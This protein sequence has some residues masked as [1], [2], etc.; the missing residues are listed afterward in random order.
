[1]GTMADKLR[2]IL[3][4][5]KAI[6]T[7]L[8]NKGAS[9]NDSTPFRAYARAIDNMSFADEGGGGGGSGEQEIAY[10]DFIYNME[11]EECTPNCSYADVLSAISSG[12][13]VIAKFGLE[14]PELNEVVM[15]SFMP[16]ASDMSMMD[17]VEFRGTLM[18]M[19]EDNAFY[20]AEIAL[21]FMSDDTV[22][23]TLATVRA[24]YGTGT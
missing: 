17:V 9:I 23:V 4:T 21:D 18:F 13:Y 14:D 6:K 11:T 10:F 15:T 22:Y 20:F 16:I 1:M 8:I 5:K 19:P 12:K 7:S 2:Y 3:E 24:S